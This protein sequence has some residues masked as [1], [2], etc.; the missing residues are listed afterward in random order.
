MA[1]IAL[2]LIAVYRVFRADIET[3]RSKVK[4]LQR[5]IPIAAASHPVK[6]YLKSGNS[7]EGIITDETDTDMFLKFNMATGEGAVVIKRSDIKY[8]DRDWKKPAE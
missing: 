4:F 3:M 8:I 2:C 1:V 6:V 7:I 5:R